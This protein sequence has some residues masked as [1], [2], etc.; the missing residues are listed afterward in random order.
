VRLE[1]GNPMYLA[2]AGQL[3]ARLGQKD[4]AIASLSRA[5]E[6]SDSF[7]GAADAKKQ[8]ATLRR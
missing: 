1:P 7:P 2:R 6:M 5:L 8:L 3:Q 4:A